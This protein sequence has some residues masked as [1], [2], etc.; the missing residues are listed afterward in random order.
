PRNHHIGWSNIQVLVGVGCI[1]YTCSVNTIEGGHIY[2]G[3]LNGSTGVD[4]YI[5][6]VFPKG[7]GMS[8]GR[9]VIPKRKR[10]GFHVGLLAINRFLLVAFMD[11]IKSKLC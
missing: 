6:F 5:G 10:H 11:R 2:G 8:R 9:K 3:W 7:I 1:G 4:P